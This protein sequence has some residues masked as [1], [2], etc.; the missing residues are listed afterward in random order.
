TEGGAGSAPSQGE[1]P[2]CRN[3]LSIFRLLCTPDR[4]PNCQVHLPAANSGPVVDTWR[5]G[6]AELP[7]SAAHIRSVPIHCGP[8]TRRRISSNHVAPREGRERTTVEGASRSSV[9][10]DLKMNA[11]DSPY[12]G[13]GWRGCCGSDRYSVALCSGDLREA[14]WGIDEGDFLG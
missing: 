2:R 13:H 8:R 5:F 10:V 3:R 12:S 9:G 6:L 14:A 4:L 1:Q 11:T 7:V